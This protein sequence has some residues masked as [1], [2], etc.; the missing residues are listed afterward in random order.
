MLTIGI[1]TYNR[2]NELS[3]LLDNLLKE[4]KDANLDNSKIEILISDNASSDGTPELVY[5]YIKKYPDFINY[6][7]NES[8]LGYDKNVNNVGKKAKYEYV[9]FMSD[10][11]MFEDGSLKKI[12]TYL[13]DNTVDI[14]LMKEKFYDESNSINIS[15]M[16]DEA[17]RNIA[18]DEFYKNGKDLME[19][20]RKVFV[21]ISGFLIKKDL[22]NSLNYTD[23]EDC[24]FIQTYAMLQ[25]FPYSSVF[26]FGEP[27]IKYRLNIKK[28]SLIKPYMKIFEVPFGLLK[29]IK[30]IKGKYSKELYEEVYNK[31]LSWSRRLMIGCK[32]R[33]YINNKL[34]VYQWMKKTYDTDKLSFWILDV[35]LLYIPDILFKIPYLIY[36]IYK[37]KVFHTN[38][39]ISTKD[40]KHT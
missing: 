12:V 13:E 17:Y 20:T 39:V 22:W 37:Y 33:E 11:D 25:V 29:I 28:D 27:M 30:S 4:I 3:E 2:K 36:R 34:E 24:W 35:P 40:M 9:L 6:Y 19:N 16:K 23:Y 38:K 18:H 5:E 8:N 10:D 7:R 26:I 21:A 15:Y 14:I 1:P 32:S 31:E